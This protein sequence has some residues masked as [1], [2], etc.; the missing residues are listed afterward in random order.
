LPHLEKFDQGLA[1][2]AVV[3]DYKND[4]RGFLNHVGII[5]AFPVES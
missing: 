5:G 2:G 4:E 3:F 1:Y